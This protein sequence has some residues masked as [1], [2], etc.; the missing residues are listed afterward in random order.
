MGLGL[1]ERRWEGTQWEKG[2]LCLAASLG[3]TPPVQAPCSRGSF[4]EAPSGSPSSSL[5][6]V[7]V[8]VAGLGLAKLPSRPHSRILLSPVPAPA[9]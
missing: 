8:P 7:T 1:P 5:A 2:Q 6:T 3:C 4:W 9:E